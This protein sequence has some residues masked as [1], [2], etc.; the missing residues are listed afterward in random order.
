MYKEGCITYYSSKYS[1]QS[2]YPAGGK[3]SLS[4][5][6]TVKQPTEDHVFT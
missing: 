4:S 5:N 3:L 6:Q 1:K 2:E